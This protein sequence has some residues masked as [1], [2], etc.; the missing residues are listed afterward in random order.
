MPKMPKVPKVPKI[1]VF[2]LLYKKVSIFVNACMS[3]LYKDVK[4]YFPRFAQN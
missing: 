1:K 2:H 3:M 4:K